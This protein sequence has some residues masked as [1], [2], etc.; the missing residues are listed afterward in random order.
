MA[1][2]KKLRVAINESDSTHCW[3]RRTCGAGW[4]K[5]EKHWCSG[6]AEGPQKAEGVLEG[7]SAQE[8]EGAQEE[9]WE[10]PRSLLSHSLLQ[11]R[12]QLAPPTTLIPAERKKTPS[13]YCQIMS[14]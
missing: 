2:E 14:K 5:L 6:E 7:E 9:V 3:R 4:R 11:G 12:R 1:G 8:A 10:A 13:F